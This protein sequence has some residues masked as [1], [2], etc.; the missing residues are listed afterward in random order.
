MLVFRERR[1]HEREPTTGEGTLS[2]SGPAG[3]LIED[4]ASVQ[5]LSEEGFQLAVPSE[6]PV[7]S[8]VRLTGARAAYFGSSCYCQS[9]SG[10]YL[11]GLHVVRQDS[12]ERLR[13]VAGEMYLGRDKISGYRQHS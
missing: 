10:K 3:A 8:M 4:Q 12:R 1:R 13:D 2:W 7:A 6:V 9:E 11:V 5:N